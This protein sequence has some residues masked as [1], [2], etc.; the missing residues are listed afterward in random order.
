MNTVK[1]GKGFEKE[2]YQI[3]KERFDE[4]EGLSENQEKKIR[5]SFDD[6]LKRKLKLNHNLNK[7]GKNEKHNKLVQK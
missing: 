6:V 4:V 7:G 3:L 2:A 1:I 5:E